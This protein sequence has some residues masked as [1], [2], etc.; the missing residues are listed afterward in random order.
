MQVDR[1]GYHERA[2]RTGGRS[3]TTRRGRRPTR[4]RTCGRGSGGS[5]Y[6]WR[7][8]CPV[9]CIVSVRGR[10]GTRGIATGTNSCRRGGEPTRG[11]R[12]AGCASATSPEL[13]R[14]SATTAATGRC[15]HRHRRKDRRRARGRQGRSCARE[16]ATRSAFDPHLRSSEGARR[17]KTRGRRGGILG[18]ATRRPP[19]CASYSTGGARRH[20]GWVGRGGPR[21]WLGWWGSGGHGP[22]AWLGV[23]AWRHRRD[24]LSISWK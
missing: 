16:C 8:G 18:V 14:P 5:G 4:R 15:L 6:Q 24:C 1:G 23:A 10:Q 3:R 20:G 22:L 19:G 11:H 7:G 9:E 2:G 17:C 13:Q 12:R 21:S